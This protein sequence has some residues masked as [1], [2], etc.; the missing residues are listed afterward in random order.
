MST[1]AIITFFLVSWS[2]SINFLYN[3]QTDCD[4]NSPNP[5]TW[6]VQLSNCAVLTFI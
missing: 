4:T 3:L 2:A 6:R 1:V 5:A